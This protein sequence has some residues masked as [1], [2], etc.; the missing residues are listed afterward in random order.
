MDNMSE[1]VRIMQRDSSL[2]DVTS[3]ELRQRNL[4]ERSDQSCQNY[5]LLFCYLYL[6]IK[7]SSYDI[8]I[9][10]ARA[11]LRRPHLP[12]RSDLNPATGALIDP[13]FAEAKVTDGL[14]PEANEALGWELTS[15]PTSEL[16]LIPR[17]GKPNFIWFSIRRCA[18]LEDVSRLLRYH[19]DRIEKQRESERRD[20]SGGY[21]MRIF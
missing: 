2:P 12:V 14:H 18:I 8:S 17:D 6:P 19:R 10:M 16:I 20:E 11:K 21:Q 13:Q 15:G 3:V 7:P 5:V 4:L 9:A 1:S